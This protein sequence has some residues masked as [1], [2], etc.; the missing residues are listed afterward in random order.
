VETVTLLSTEMPSHTH[1]VLANTGSGTTN[2]P[3]G[4]SWA[5]AHSGKTPYKTYS[6]NTTSP[7]PMSPQALNLAG[8]SLPHNNLPPYLVM[9]FCIALQGIYPSRP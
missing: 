3:T 9:N 8:F 1:T 2:D 6:A 5:R 4:A 7:T